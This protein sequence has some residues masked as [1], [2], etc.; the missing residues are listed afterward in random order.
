MSNF[1]TT[2]ILIQE[3]SGTGERTLA[4]SKSFLEFTGS[5]EGG[6]F[7]SQVIYFSDKSSRS[8]GYFWKTYDEWK[9]H[10]FMTEYSIRK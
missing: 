6:V 9:D 4:I 7:L 1:E 8:D 2:K 10:T 5:L 3:M